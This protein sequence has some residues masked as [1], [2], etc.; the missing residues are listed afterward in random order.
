MRLAERL[1]H[2][3][4]HTPGLLGLAQ[5]IL[6]GL[7][8]R[9][10]RLSGGRVS[11]APRGARVLLLTT[12]GRRSST[13]RTTPVLYTRDGDS[14]LVV[15]SNWGAPHPPHWLLNL[16]AHPAATVEIGR[17]RHPVTATELTGAERADVWAAL[18]R[19]WPLYADLAARAATRDLPV[20]RLSIV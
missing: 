14:Y 8:T 12:S 6:P 15:A 20:I 9:L 1:R 13:P 17:I 2:R 19:S 3:I 18:V 5:R 7:D 16:R 11:L 4:L 10:L